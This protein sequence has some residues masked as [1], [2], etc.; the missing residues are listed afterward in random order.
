MTLASSAHLRAHMAELY[1]TYEAQALDEAAKLIDRVETLN[2]KIAN[3]TETEKKE[4]VPN[5]RAELEQLMRELGQF[6]NI[7][8]KAD[9]GKNQVSV[10]EKSSRDALSQVVGQIL[11]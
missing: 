11:R 3:A 2:G 1:G 7:A 8:R 10:A 5:W 6:D 9:E 4:K